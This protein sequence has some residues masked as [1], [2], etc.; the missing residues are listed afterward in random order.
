MHTVRGSIFW[1]ARLAVIALMLAGIGSCH[2]QVQQPVTVKFLRYGW[3]PPDDLPEVEKFTEDFER[4]TG[5][6]LE[7]IRGAPTETT[8]QPTLIRR[9]LQQRA[10]GPDVVEADVTWLGTLKDDLLDLRP[11]FQSEAQSM[12]PAIASSYIMDGKVLAM[13]YQNQ[14][15]VLEY[16]ADLLQKYGYDHPPRTWTELETMALRIQ[17]SEQALGNKDFW[18]YI[19]PGAAEE[20]LTCNALEWQVD[21]GGGRIIERDGTISV[22]NP[23]AIRAWERARH[24]IGWISPPS[25]KEYRELDVQSAFQSGRSAFVRVWAAEAGGLPTRERPELRTLNWWNK[26]PFGEAAFTAVPAGS[27]ARAATLGGAGLFISKYSKHPQEAA[28]LLR[29]VL[30]SELESFQD[31]EIHSSPRESVIYDASDAPGQ[32]SASSL[33]DRS[34]AIIVARPTNISALHYDQVSTAYSNAVHAVLTDKK[35]ASDAASELEQDLVRITGLH[36]G[37]PTAERAAIINR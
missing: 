34:R 37:S 19:W 15:G 23:A 30:R 12:P 5:S 27:M 32:K 8:D 10:E 6:K 4:Q 18:G 25:V 28:T 9:L 13:P 1:C 24:W 11:Y 21:E 17:T 20:S 2:R 33:A 7:I 26:P 29:F 16:R 22:N 14:A 35:K 36:T 3:L 31:L